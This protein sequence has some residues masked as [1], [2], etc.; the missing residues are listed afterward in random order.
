VGLTAPKQLN[1][2]FDKIGNKMEIRGLTGPIFKACSFPKKSGRPNVVN[3][4]Q[5]DAKVQAGPVFI[6]N[7]FGPA[8]EAPKRQNM[9]AVRVKA[10][11]AAVGM[12]AT[13]GGIVAAGVL[14]SM[15][16]PG[17]AAFFAHAGAAIGI[18]GT[19]VFSASPIGWVILGV[20]AAAALVV[21]TVVAVK[22]YKARQAAKAD[23]RQY[24]GGMPF[25]Y[26]PMVPGQAFETS[27]AKKEIEIEEQAEYIP[28]SPVAQTRPSDSPE[29]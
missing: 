4:A 29:A 28:S 3:V 25:M 13:A 22:A 14:H 5:M 24:N 16:V 7:P 9:A 10:G 8:L 6:G 12:A 20:L 19:A 18:A 17:V 27:F 2:V 1:Y 23:A 21:L 11:I 15:W 26:P